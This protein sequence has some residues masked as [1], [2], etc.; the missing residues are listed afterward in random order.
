MWEHAYLEVGKQ[1][2]EF[3]VKHYEEGSEFG[4]N[5]GKISKLTVKHK[6][7]IVLNYDRGW[8]VRPKDVISKEAYKILLKKYN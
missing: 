7:E 8:D 3:W 2:V 1:M 4:I 6:N 5:G